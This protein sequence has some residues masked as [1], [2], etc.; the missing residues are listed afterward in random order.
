MTAPLQPPGR[1]NPLDRTR[2]PVPLSEARS[3]AALGLAAAAAEG[4][5]ALQVCSEC[6][7]VQYPPRDVCGTCLGDRLPWREV[8]PGGEVVAVTT[9]QIAAE[10]YFRERAPWRSGLVA[11]DCGPRIV[12]H[13][14][15]ACGT[16][17]RV[18]LDL[19]LDHAGRGAVFAMPEV[20]MPHQ[21]DDPELRAFT[22]DPKFRRVLITD[23][24]SATAPALVKALL[25]AGA[26][27]IFVGVAEA[28]KPLD[29]ARLEL[30]PEVEIVPLD[31]T[32]A[33]SV[34]ELAARIGDKVDILINNA[35]HVR[36]GGIVGSDAISARETFET[37]CLGLMRLAAAFGPVMRA[38]AADAERNAVAFVTL[39]S[40]WALAPDPEHGTYSASQAA[41]RALNGVIRAEM[42]PAGIR[43]VDVLTGPI[44]DAWHQT[45]RP[46]KVAPATIA[47]AIV[48]ALREGREEAV[49]GDIAREIHAKWAED[50][51]LLR[52][53]IR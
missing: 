15:G 39:L 14:H 34:T 22:A 50:P 33:N 7:T 21:E 32:E 35:G 31:V 24:R 5:F 17:S 36:P 1:K 40:A 29:R 41:V 48:A 19:K 53:E 28:W 43:V 6:G 30:G 27:R 46:P 16:G 11:L 2:A 26:A 18:R 37:N 38:R 42:R 51:R 45:I 13:L 10:L 25:G 12:A 3:R 9:T 23:G 44:E 4:R 49:V 52:Q 20:A 47:A 8:P